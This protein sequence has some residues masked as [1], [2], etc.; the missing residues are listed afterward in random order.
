MNPT[1]KQDQVTRLRFRDRSEPRR[2][3]HVCEALQTFTSEGSVNLEVGCGGKQYG[4]FVR[5][6]H[7]GLDLQRGPY[8]GQGADTIGSAIHMPVRSGSVD[9]VFMV[10]TLL[11]MDEWRGPLE[12]SCRVLKEGGR[13]LIF[14][15]KPRTAVRLGYPGRFTPGDIV[16]KLRSYG[17]ESREHSEFLPLY[18]VGPLRF[19]ALR[20]PVSR[21]AYL[22]GRWIIIS[23]VKAPA[24]SNS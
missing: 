14:D 23:G 20:R 15:Y 16:T 4:P 21:A 8:A 11:F 18:H 5:G 6:R 12:E 24:A 22:A 1:E 19:R 3:P 17:V 13:F 2:Y 7:F 10:A 9:L